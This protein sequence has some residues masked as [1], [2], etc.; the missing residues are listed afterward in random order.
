MSAPPILQV[1]GLRVSHRRR[2]GSRFEAV[3]GVGFSI[4]PRETV[5]I[6]GESGC[7]KTTTARAVARLAEPSA[8]SIRFLGFELARLRGRALR[9]A[10]RE[11]QM[12]FQDPAGSLDPRWT[13]GASVAEP[14]AGIPT[15]E[16]GARVGRL[17]G[18]VG[19][20]PALA[21][22]FPHELSGGQKQRV[23][24]ARALA[25]E[26]RL[27]VLDEPTS[28]LDVSVRAQ[29]VNLL[30]DLRESRGLSLLLITHDLA[31]ARVLADRILVMRAGRI[32]EEGE[33]ESLLSAP[34]DPAT[35]ALIDAVPAFPT[36]PAGPAIPT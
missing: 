14:L 2:D 9:A 25:P 1:E 32:V 5:A 3:A 36:F 16:I 6:V 22:R 15:K 23:A 10:R 33:A 19:L 21:A 30:V 24:I 11:L 27:L 7:G 12:V 18:S 8:G 20:D 4:A 13:V 34:R 26:P 17:L 31:V 35:R 28:A 29:I